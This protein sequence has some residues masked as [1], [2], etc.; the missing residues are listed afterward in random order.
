MLK[1]NEKDFKI[2]MFLFLLFSLFGLYILAAEKYS[3]LI[4]LPCIVFAGGILYAVRSFY[5]NIFLFCFLL[6]LFT[7]LLCGQVINK[8]MHV[9]GYNFSPAYFVPL[10]GH[11]WIQNKT[12]SYK[13]NYNYN[14][15]RY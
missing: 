10:V 1:V 5:D 13:K 12:K 14:N 11:N 7:F 8:F 6:C 15:F 9:Y 4:I 2:F 3:L